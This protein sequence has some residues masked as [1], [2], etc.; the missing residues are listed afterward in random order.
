MGKNIGN[1]IS[2]NAIGK[3]SQKLLD[4]A[5]QSATDALKNTSKRVTQKTAE[6]NGALIDNNTAKRITKVSQN[7]QQNNSETIT[8]EHDKRNTQRKIYLL[9]KDRK[10]MII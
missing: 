3:Y 8:N 10:S 2:K 1:N 5:N 4:H 7:S 6:A 9:K